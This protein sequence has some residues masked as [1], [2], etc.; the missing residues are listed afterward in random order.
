MFMSIE[1]S[2]SPPT[3]VVTAQILQ[4]QNALEDLSFLNTYN[5]TD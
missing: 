1:N 4:R 2:S 3:F 5:N